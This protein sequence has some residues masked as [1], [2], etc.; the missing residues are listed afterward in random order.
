MSFGAYPIYFK[1]GDEIMPP[2]AIMGRVLFFFLVVIAIT[3][4]V[5]WLVTYF[6]GYF[7]KVGVNKVNIN[8]QF[9]DKKADYL[10]MEEF[11]KE[12][13]EFESWKRRRERA[14]KK[15]G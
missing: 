8:H 4:G 9:N 7:A 3:Y 15:D 13:K 10:T 12:K 6:W 11:E 5:I 1:D 2:V 14:R